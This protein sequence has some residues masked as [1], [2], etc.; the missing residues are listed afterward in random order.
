MKRGA[1]VLMVLSLSWATAMA[2]WT[3]DK[4]HSNALFTVRH[5]VVSE[6]TGYFK[7]F[8]VILAS[9]KDDF[10]D[11]TIEATVKTASVNTDNESRDKDLRSDNFFSVDKFPEMKFKSKK[12][13]KTGDNAYKIT[14]DLTIRDVTKEVTFDATL[15]GTIA[16]GRDTRAGWKATATVNRFD[17]GMKWNRMIETGGLV[18]GENVLITLNLEFRKAQ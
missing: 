4:S 2:Q 18:V 1:F 9:S 5:M 17:Y 8:E 6:V 16:T 11:A 15:F 3:H 14:G 10:T 13:E 12:I 7:E